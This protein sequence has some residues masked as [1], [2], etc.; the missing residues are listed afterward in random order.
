MYDLNDY[1]Y[2][3]PDNLIAQQPVQQRDQS[4]L[5][6]LCKNSGGVEHRHFYEIPKML[7]PG[8]ILVINNTQVVPGRLFGQKETGGQVELLLLEY[9]ENSQDKQNENICVNKCL[10][11]ASKPSKPGTIIYFEEGLKATVLNNEN[12]YYKVQFSC[13]GSFDKTLHRIGK[14]P[15]PPYIKRNPGSFSDF[16]EDNTSYQ[17]VYAEKKGAIAAPTAGLHFTES[18]MNQI[19]QKG[20]DIAPVTL[21]VGYGSFAPVRSSDIR[22]H[23]IH[24]EIFDI[25]ENTAQKI[26]E[27]KNQ[28]RRIVAVGTTC[29]RTLEYASDKEGRLASGMGTCDL[30]IYP[31]YRFKIVDA[32]ITNF[33]LPKSTLIM[34]V[35]AFARRKNILEAYSKAIENN[36]RFY[37]Y[38]DAMFIE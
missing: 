19:K 36:Y 6:R 20:I 26:T 30:F 14:M 12:G 11:K 25:S 15:V 21:H 10:I 37:S 3:L 8:D 24:S 38:G 17:T 34:L 32:L 1:H 13:S 18:L 33:H 35:S 5:M 22:Q 29:V 4:R 31:G 23:K 2:D 9:S 27:G 28:G 16:H 7:R